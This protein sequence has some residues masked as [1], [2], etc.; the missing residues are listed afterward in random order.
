MQLHTI[1]NG[2]NKGFKIPKESWIISMKCNFL[3]YYQLLLKPIDEIWYFCSIVNTFV[4]ILLFYSFNTHWVLCKV[5]CTMAAQVSALLRYLYSQ[6][7]E[8]WWLNRRIFG[9]ET[10]ISQKTRGDLRLLSIHPRAWLYPD[11]SEKIF[12]K[13]ELPNNPT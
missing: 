12:S 2:L 8:V 3:S 10:R 13:F 1:F 6:P 4:S 11:L 7:G 9:L 5:V